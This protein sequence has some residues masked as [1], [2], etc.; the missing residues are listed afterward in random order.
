MGRAGAGPVVCFRAG[1]GARYRRARYTSDIA[2]APV[3]TD[4]DEAIA[5]A[6][7]RIS[8]E[9]IDVFRRAVSRPRLRGAIHRQ[10]S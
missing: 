8:G 9:P 1:C 6:F 2:V 4:L 7:D 5:G 10:G 3:D